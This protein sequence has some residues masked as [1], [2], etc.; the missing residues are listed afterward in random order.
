MLCGD[1]QMTIGVDLPV[2]ATDL[3][4]GSNIGRIKDHEI[5]CNVPTIETT[6]GILLGPSARYG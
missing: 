1:Q 2:K 4:T 6:I 3:R 5:E